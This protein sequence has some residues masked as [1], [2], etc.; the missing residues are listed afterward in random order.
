MFEV[1]IDDLALRDCAQVAGWLCEPKNN[2]WLYSEWRGRTVDERLVALVRMSPRNALWSVR[3]GAKLV[4]IVA[5]SQVDHT[6]CIA[7]VW[8]LIGDR[9]VRNRGVATRALELATRAAFVNYGLNC[10]TASVMSSNMAS[11]RAL[12]KAGF[13]LAGRFRDAM[14]LNG[15]AVDRLL[16]DIVPMDLSEKC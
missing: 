3:V 5:L 12:E 2:Q 16:Y 15:K 9:S 8:Y 10:L 11:R 7:A 14:I 4:G 1:T 13:K 6:D